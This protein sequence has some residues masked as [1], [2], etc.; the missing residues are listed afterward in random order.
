MATNAPKSTS[1]VG[2]DALPIV[3]AAGV[4]KAWTHN[5]GARALKVE[6]LSQT[7]HAQQAD[8]VVTATQPSVNQIVLSSPGGG[9][10]IGL[11]TWTLD[12]SEAAAAPAASVF[13]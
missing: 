3:L 13:V 5:K 1:I 8:T 11:I 10:F 6:V 12:S 9:N 7:N 4:P 2:T